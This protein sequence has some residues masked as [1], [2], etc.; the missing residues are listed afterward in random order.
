MFV[1]I[2]EFR[3]SPA[4]VAEFKEIYGENG[5]WVKL[6]QKGSGYLGTELLHDP[7]DVHHFL[8]IDRWISAT[9]YEAFLSYWN[10]E[11]EKLD[12]RYKDLTESETLLGKWENIRPETR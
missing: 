7:S 3:V 1:I 4:R 5:P 11:Y 12:A 8:T 10:S 2:W 6:F 9:D